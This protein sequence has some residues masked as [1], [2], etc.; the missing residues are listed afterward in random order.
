MAAARDSSHNGSNHKQSATSYS[1]CQLGSRRYHKVHELCKLNWPTASFW[2][3][4][5]G[6]TG[7]SSIQ[8]ACSHA[9]SLHVNHKICSVWRQLDEWHSSDCG[10]NHST[11]PNATGNLYISGARFTKNLTPDLW[12]SST[13]AG[14]TPSLWIASD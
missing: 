11:L 13:Y 9:C 12:Q 4:T 7:Q 5:W 1:S 6:N 3:H 2:M 8:I 14:L 10:T